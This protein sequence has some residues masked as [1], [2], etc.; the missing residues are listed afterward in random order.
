[1]PSASTFEALH[2]AFP[3]VPMR[4]FVLSAASSAGIPVEPTTA[5][6]DDLPNETLLGILAARLEGSTSWPGIAS[7][8]DRQL[9]DDPW[10]LA[11]HDREP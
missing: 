8:E 10:T 3:G 2:R 4:A 7:P 6:Y 9:P 11:A 1:M 5:T